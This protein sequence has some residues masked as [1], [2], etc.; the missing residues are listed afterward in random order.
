ATTRGAGPASH[1][2]GCRAW[3]F[4]G[5]DF[6]GARRRVCRQSAATPA[7]HLATAGAYAGANG[8]Q[9]RFGGY[10]IETGHVWHFSLLPADAP[11]RHGHVHARNSV[12]GAGGHFLWGAGV[13]RAIGHEEAD[14]LQQREPHGIRH[15]WVLRAER[16]QL[17]R[18]NLAD[19][20]SWPIDSRLV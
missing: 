11:R 14:C 17:A 10:L 16:D 3:I 12:V 2:D 20:Q 13:A 9:H 15:P 8:R 19:D 18:R 7:A 5:L 4:A 1:S 6:P